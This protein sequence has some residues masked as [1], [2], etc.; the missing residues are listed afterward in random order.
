MVEGVGWGKGEGRH[1]VMGRED[2]DNG[3]I[4]AAS[5]EGLAQVGGGPRM[6]GGCVLGPD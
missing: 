4:S 2:S 1:E 6:T 5:Q 3:V